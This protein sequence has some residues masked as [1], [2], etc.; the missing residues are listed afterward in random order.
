[1]IQ[2]DAQ[3]SVTEPY[4]KQLCIDTSNKVTV[5]QALWSIG[6]DYNNISVN[7]NTYVRVADRPYMVFEDTLYVVKR[8]DNSV[9]KNFCKS[10]QTLSV[11]LADVP[12]H[13]EIKLVTDLPY[14]DNYQ[15][16]SK[17]KTQIKEYMVKHK[18]KGKK[19]Q[20]SHKSLKS[21]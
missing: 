7:H 11:K 10:G 4:L 16:N 15:E 18:H 3:F 13:K 2:E 1:M 20:K 5:R 17:L 8:R 6:G 19:F 9:I 21:S 12:N 14:Q